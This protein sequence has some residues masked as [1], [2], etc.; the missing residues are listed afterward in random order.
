MPLKVGLSS[1]CSLIIYLFIYFLDGF[2]KCKYL[3]QAFGTAVELNWTDM[4]MF[5]ML[6]Q[7][8][9]TIPKPAHVLHSRY[10]QRTD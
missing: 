5:S 3:V 7:H 9:D 1:C 2:A 6:S 8:S 10:V 4:N